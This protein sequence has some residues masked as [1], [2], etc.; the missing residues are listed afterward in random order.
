MT[1]AATAW[2]STSIGPTPSDEPA[3]TTD[4]LPGCPRALLSVVR[5]G[6]V[7]PAR[8]GSL[9]RCGT[10]RRTGLRPAGRGRRAETA[11]AAAQPADQPASTLAPRSLPRSHGFDRRAARRTSR[12]VAFAVGD[13]RKATRI[14]RRDR[15][16]D[17]W[18]FGN[19]QPHART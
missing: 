13:R 18:Q 7:S 4:R 15:S 11:R 14:T 5:R 17:R 12:G 2:W 19:T 3:R 1:I 6:I 8:H 9:A 10:E 16:A